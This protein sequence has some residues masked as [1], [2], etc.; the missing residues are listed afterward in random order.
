MDF[1]EA[2]SKPTN[3]T[4]KEIQDIHSR[5]QEMVNMGRPDIAL[6][7]LGFL[8]SQNQAIVGATSDEQRAVYID[9]QTADSVTLFEALEDTETFSDDFLSALASRLGLEFDPEEHLEAKLE[10]A[11]L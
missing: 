9:K 10:P 3:W 1:N 2:M 4:E 7:T 5:V 11:L 8:V 6:D